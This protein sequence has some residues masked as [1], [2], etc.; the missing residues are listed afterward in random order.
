[1]PNELDPAWLS[2]IGKALAFLCV[3]EVSRSDPK[4]VPDLPAKVK[5][6]EGIGLPTSEAAALLGTTANSVKT[7]LRQREKTK[8]GTRAKKGKK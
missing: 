1:L 7:N 2:I 8:G 5:F 6:L 4:R 3:Q